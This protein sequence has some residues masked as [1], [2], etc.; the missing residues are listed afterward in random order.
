MECGCSFRNPCGRTPF[1]EI[2][3]W[4]VPFP[5][6]VRCSVSG[7]DV[8]RIVNV[9]GRSKVLGPVCTTFVE[10]NVIYGSCSTLKK[11]LLISFPI[12]HP[13]SRIHTRC[14]NLDVQ[15]SILRMSRRECQRGVPFFKRTFDRNRCLHCKFNCAFYGRDL[16][17]GNFPRGLCS[18]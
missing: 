10:L 12:L 11:S 9:P 4:P 13:A 15:D 5:E 14:L 16:E 6:S 8:P 17:N 3:P 2:E 7:L 18:A 1:P